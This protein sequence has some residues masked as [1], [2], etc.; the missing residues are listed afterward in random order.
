MKK[1]FYL[2]SIAFVHMLF[3]HKNSFAE[4]L[5]KTLN[6][7]NETDTKLGLI[8]NWIAAGSGCKGSNASPADME[9]KYT[10][11]TSKGNRN[12]Y[13]VQGVLNIPSYELKSPIT[14]PPKTIIFA[15]ECAVRIEILPPPRMKVKTVTGTA[16]AQF[17][18][19]KTVA[20]KIQ[21]LLYFNGNV[22]SA[23]L[24][25]SEKGE[26]VGY[27]DVEMKLVPGIFPKSSKH[28]RLTT[29]SSEC[30]SPFMYGFDFT[31][32]ADRTNTTDIVNIKLSPNNK[33]LNFTV[34][35]EPCL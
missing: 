1:Y 27:R 30:G 29:L 16:T 26:Q 10:A 35:F 9:L 28:E 4:N 15:R 14:P 18:K 13:G 21:S 19:D 5:K 3:V 17:S 8:G 7:K 24:N 20:T 12:I 6:K 11:I 33:A 23:S 34:E 22:V 25:E 2:G 32:L 31:F